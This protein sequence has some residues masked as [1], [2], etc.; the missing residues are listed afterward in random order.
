[1]KLQITMR[2][3]IHNDYQSNLLFS[4][5]KYFFRKVF[6]KNNFQLYTE[7]EERGES[8]GYVGYIFQC[9]STNVVEDIMQEFNIL[10]LHTFNNF[11]FSQKIS[12]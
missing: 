9:D 5:N 8:A 6:N 11:I 1:M 7:Q 3:I 10:K 2:R 4:K 12:S